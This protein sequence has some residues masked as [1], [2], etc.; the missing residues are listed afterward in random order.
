[1]IQRVQTIW[2]L[3]TALVIAIFFFI[4]DTAIV[5]AIVEINSSN[6]LLDIELGLILILAITAIFLY[7]KRPLQ[8]KC[9][10]GILLLLAF[11]Y[12]SLYLLVQYPGGNDVVW[13]LPVLIPLVTVIFVLLAIRAIQKDEKLVRSLDRLR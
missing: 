6:Y 13:K 9:C 8:I 5:T 3:L 1:M 4:P 12:I 7:K 2:L 11:F 10:Y